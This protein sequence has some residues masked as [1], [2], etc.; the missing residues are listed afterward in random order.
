MFLRESARVCRGM[1]RYSSRRMTLGKRTELR[2][3]C[4]AVTDTSSADATPFSTSTRARR[5]AQTLIGS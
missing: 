1:R 3:E 4:T 5:A 2:A